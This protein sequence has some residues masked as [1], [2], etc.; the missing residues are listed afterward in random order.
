MAD[1]IEAA[2]ALD[3]EVCRAEAQARFPIE[4]MIASYLDRYRQLVRCAA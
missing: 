4:R 3:P 2:G 1:A